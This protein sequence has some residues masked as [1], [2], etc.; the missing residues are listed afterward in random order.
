MYHPGTAVQRKMSGVEGTGV[1]GSM[2][3]AGGSGV[4]CGARS[5]LGV[6]GAAGRDRSVVACRLC[7]RR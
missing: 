4:G 3:G 5:E 1:M 2:T 6:G 7:L